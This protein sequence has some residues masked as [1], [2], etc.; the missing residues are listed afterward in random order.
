MEDKVEI[1]SKIEK[2][3]YITPPSSCVFVSTISKDGMRNVAPFAQFMVASS[4]PPILALGI[5]PKSDTWQNICDTKE[6]VVAIPTKE[7][8]EKFVKTADK[9]DDEFLYAGLTPYE[10]THITPFKIKECSVNIECKL[11]WQKESGNH[12]VVCGDVIS[13]D[14]D[15][16]LEQHAGDDVKMR[17]SFDAIYHIGNRNNFGIGFAEIKKTNSDS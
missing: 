12:W 13:A 11:N 10:S 1:L 15:Q 7:I 6:F 3:N 9:V 4:K 14:I 16:G 8:L 17:T 5:S 2:I